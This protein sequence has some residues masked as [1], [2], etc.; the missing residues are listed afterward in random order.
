MRY[1]FIDLETYSSLDLKEVGAYKYVADKDFEVLICGY[2]FDHDPVTVV[3][4]LCGEPWPEELIEALN[5]PDII[6]IAHNSAFE[7]LCLKRLGIKTDVSQWRDTLLLAA[8]SGLPLALKDVCDVLNIKERKLATGLLLIRFFS[9]PCKPTKANPDKTRNYPEDDP[10]RWEMY[11]EYNDYDVRSEREIFYKL[12][13]ELH[14]VW[15]ES[16]QLNYE[17][18]QAINSKGILL[19]LDLA[20]KALKMYDE[21]SES[22]LAEAVKLTGLENP[23]SVAQLAD[24]IEANTGIRPESFEKSKLPAL[25]ELYSNYPDIIQ[26]LDLRK[27]LA[28]SS[29]KKYQMMLN[30]AMDDNR[31]RGTFQFYGANR[32]GR[33]A[34]R[35]LQLQNLAKNHI[36]HIELAR[37]AV[38]TYDTNTVSMLYDDVADILSQLIR[39]AI[40]APDDMTFAVADF[41]AIEARVVSWYAD[42]KWRLDVF[43]G[44]GKIYE[45]TGAK[46][47]G[48]PASAIT[49]GSDL[50]QKSKISELALGYGGGINALERMGGH[51]MGLSKQVE[52]DLVRKWRNANPCIVKMWA[53]LETG[54]TMAI[55]Y[56]KKI[57]AT[58]RK[59]VFDCDGENLTIQLPS[60]RKLYYRH[61]HFKDARAGGFSYTSQNI[62]YEG[63][64]DKG[65]WTEID[66]YG[67][68]LTE[69]IVQATARDILANSMQNL[70][71]G[72]YLPIC[73]IH[74]ECIIEI[75]KQNAEE[76]YNKV[77]SLMEQKPAWLGTMPL[78]ADGYITPFYKKD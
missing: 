38:K 1:L 54:A 11:K 17:L 23:K 69:N 41:S 10:E 5:N 3:D 29:I 49:K 71:A 47:F 26:M 63:Y 25:Y 68:K 27:K 64:N 15:P 66:T 70:A 20:A 48:V 78:K 52:L 19:D 12:T 39:T 53:E 2:A 72:G 36:D 50:R 61:P 56:H 7:R 9:C 40:V 55:K 57:V 58:A 28:K 13:E 22:V 18:D 6:K 32:T 35:L 37:D 14:V 77:V 44:D 21:Y 8:Y 65:I 4:L 59:L 16:E 42:E 34:G 74:D 46:M 45:A 33:W 30:C 67:G 24:C 62:F 51:D 43:N 31:I 60:G 73:H 76:H 75:P